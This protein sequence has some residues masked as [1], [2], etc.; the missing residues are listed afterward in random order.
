MCFLQPDGSES[1]F[2]SSKEAAS[3]AST[4]SLSMCGHVL[5]PIKGRAAHTEVLAL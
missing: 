5:A 3:G 1:N 2:T 4:L